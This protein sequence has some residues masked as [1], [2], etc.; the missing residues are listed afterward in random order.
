M[1]VFSETASQL[2]KLYQQ[3]VYFEE[4]RIILGKRIMDAYMKKVLAVT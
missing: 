3:G 1:C 4:M 2:H